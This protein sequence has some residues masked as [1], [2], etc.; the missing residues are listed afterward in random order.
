MS[1][2]SSLVVCLVS[3]MLLASAATFFAEEKISYTIGPG[4]VL[5][6]S[7][8]QHPELNRTVTVR[9]DGK[10][11]FSLIGDVD[12]TG[13]TPAELNQVITRK[14]S[15][16][17]Q[18]PEVTVIVTNIRSGQIIV[19]GQVAK[20]GV[21]PVGESTTVVEAIAIAGGYTDMADLRSV[22]ITRK[23]GAKTS[24]V[25]KVNLKKV[26]A[27]GDKSKDVILER[28]DVVYMPGKKSAWDIF[29]RWFTRGILPI[30]GM[31]YMIDT[32]PRH[33]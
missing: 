29:D 3:V 4:D 26:I 5:E 20:P 1:T 25:I 22:T 19:L 11:S 18:N 28:G 16:Y 21:Y 15:E 17:V 32:L 10:I 33:H 30:V 27:E 8:W 2:K 13:L 7:V 31:I 12:T 9:P 14:L 6:I 24:K 23:S